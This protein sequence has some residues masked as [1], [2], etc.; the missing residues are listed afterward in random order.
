M[1]RRGLRHARAV[2]RRTDLPRRAAQIIETTEER[3]NE[4]EL[5]LPLTCCRCRADIAAITREALVGNAYW[6]PLTEA[7]GEPPAAVRHEH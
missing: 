6:W 7:P 4:A 1:A 5:L 3:V 2:G